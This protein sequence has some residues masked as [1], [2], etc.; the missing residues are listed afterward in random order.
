MGHVNSSHQRLVLVD[1]ENL[2]GTGDPTEHEVE[3]I[4]QNLFEILG[5]LSDTLFEVASSHH[6]APAVRFGFPEGRHHWR[7]GPDGADLAL[8]EAL[9]STWRTDAFHE[10]VIA[11]GD[12]IF[13]EAAAALVASGTRCTVISRRASL[14]ARLC[15]AAISA[16]YI[17]DPITGEDQ[18]DAA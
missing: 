14:S 4:R 3:R 2:L 10:V 5:D 11:S 15:L 6:A 18:A 12:G 8:L 1:P 13:A 16:T 17:D 7:S 9:D